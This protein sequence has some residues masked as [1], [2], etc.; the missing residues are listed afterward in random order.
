[1]TLDRD[2]QVNVLHS[3]LDIGEMLVCSGAEIN[4]VEDTLA[5]IGYAYGAEH[6]DIFAIMSS[7]IVT[8]VFPGHR[9]ITLTRRITTPGPT[10][11]TKIEELNELSRECCR[12]PF[13]PEELRNRVSSIREERLSVRDLVIGSLIGSFSFAVFFGGSIADGLASAGIALLIC[14]LQKKLVRYMPNTVTSNLTI[15]VIIGA[16]IWIVTRL[17]PFLHQDWV[18]IGDIMLLIP[19]L[20]MTNAIRDVLIWDTIAG[21]MR[22]IES[23]LWAG[24]IA[25]G[26]M[27]SFWFLHEVAV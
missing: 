7:I 18:A 24:A 1:M 16:V 15:S 6:M 3:L 9:E 19:G 10:D 26:F 21:I 17:I 27:V 20:A 8:A 14:R 23:L 12:S 11:F 22:L 5:R 4:R 13:S 25:A 2:R